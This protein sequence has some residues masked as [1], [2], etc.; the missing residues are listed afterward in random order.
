MKPALPRGPLPPP[1]NWISPEDEQ[2]IRKAENFP[3][4]AFE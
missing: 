1:R 4:N 2:T 3:W